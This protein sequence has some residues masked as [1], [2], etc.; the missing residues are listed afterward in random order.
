MKIMNSKL[1]MM[2]FGVGVMFAPLDEQRTKEVGAA[3]A[4]TS[5][6]VGI[7]AMSAEAIPVVPEV[8]IPAVMVGAGITAFG[9]FIGIDSAVQGRCRGEL[10]NPMKIN[11]RQYCDQF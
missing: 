10:R 5:I 8:A 11:V 2:A 9:T 4:I 1:M 6:G 3:A 7:V